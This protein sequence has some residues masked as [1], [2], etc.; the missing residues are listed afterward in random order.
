MTIRDYVVETL[1]GSVVTMALAVREL[2]GAEFD[3]TWLATEES[4]KD[5]HGFT[6]QLKTSVFPRYLFVPFDPC[7]VRWRR[8]RELRGV[9]RVIWTDDPLKP[10]ALPPGTVA[11]LKAQ[12]QA[13]EFKLKPKAGIARG[14][15]V[16]F[17]AGPFAGHSGKVTESKGERLLVLMALFGSEREVPVQSGMVRRAAE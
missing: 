11:R 5:R 8:I 7:D 1:D 12:F 2:I 17:E 6:R 16:V 9:K 15:N 13:G 4:Y 3:A 14:D 10:F